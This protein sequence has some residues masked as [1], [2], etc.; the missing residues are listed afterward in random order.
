MKKL[1]I[2]L[3][4]KHL[5]LK[6]GQEF[7]FVNQKS[8]NNTYYFDTTRLMKVDYDAPYVINGCGFPT[9]VP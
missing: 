1:I 4:R 9:H 5:G 8:K 7:R 2:F 3:I 6:L